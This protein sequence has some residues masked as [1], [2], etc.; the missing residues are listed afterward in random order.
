ME[1]SNFIFEGKAYPARISMGALRAFRKETG[2]DFLKSLAD[3][4]GEDLGVM[5]WCAVKAQCRVEE[6]PFDMSV[7]D[8]L[9][10]V[11][12]DEVSAWYNGSPDTAVTQDSGG[13]ESKKKTLPG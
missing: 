4:T 13:D 5:L 6:I 2:R 9:D 10:R 12:P 3:L 8:F 1:A 11:T 7:D